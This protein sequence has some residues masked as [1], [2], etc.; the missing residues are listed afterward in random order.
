MECLT[1][2]LLYVWKAVIVY[3]CTTLL[4]AQFQNHLIYIAQVSQH[5]IRATCSSR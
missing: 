2:L 1:V 3:V 4:I 5:L